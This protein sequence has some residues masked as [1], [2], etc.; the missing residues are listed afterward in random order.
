MC[1]EGLGL[2][3]AG[4][5]LPVLRR[6]G[7]LRDKHEE[8][9]VA[10]VLPQQGA[11]SQHCM[12]GEQREIHTDRLPVFRAGGCRKCTSGQCRRG[13]MSGIRAELQTVHSS[14]VTSLH[15]FSTSNK[16]RPE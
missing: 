16:F 12:E 7:P 4:S 14:Y 15:T 13:R 6:P 2:P 10:V 8:K 3:R 9:K 11:E 5:L 1:L